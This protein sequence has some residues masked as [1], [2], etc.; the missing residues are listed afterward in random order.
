MHLY[1]YDAS[2]SGGTLTWTSNTIPMEKFGAEEDVSTKPLN[3]TRQYA[4][5]MVAVKVKGNLVNET[6]I[7][8]YYNETTNYGGPKG[9]LLYVTGTLTNTQDGIID[10]SHGAYAEGEDV[11]L[12]KNG[13]NTY[14]YVPAAGGEGGSQVGHGNGSSGID[15][16]DTTTIPLTTLSRRATGGGGS[17]SSYQGTGMAGGP[18]TS[19]S[20]G[21]GGGGTIRPNSYTPTAGDLYGG[22]GGSGLSYGS[23]ACGGAGNPSGPGHDS[24]AQQGTGGLLIIYANEF[25]NSG[26]IYAK[27]A[28]GAEN[29]TY[30]S[31]R[32]GSSGGGSINVF[33]NTLVNKGSFSVT[34]GSTNKKDNQGGAGGSG[35][36]STGSIATGTYVAN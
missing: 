17:G 19:Y 24:A 3:G 10:N 25:S 15:G 13:N 22:A 34:G 36:V 33:Y 30:M 35:S 31:C 21:T 28:N 6:T 29:N 20:G 23:W 8:P 5:A 27:G 1:V 7:Q 16:T 2:N 9:F 4:E 14:E 11:W 18:G 12:W 26:N 32:G